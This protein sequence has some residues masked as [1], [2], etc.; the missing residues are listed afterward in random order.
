MPFVKFMQTMRHKLFY[1]ILLWVVMIGC[2]LLNKSSLV[3]WINSCQVRVIVRIYTNCGVDYRM[4]ILLYE[5]C[6]KAYMKHILVSYFKALHIKCHYMH[7]FIFYKFK[8]IKLWIKVVS[9][10]KLS[11]MCNWYTGTAKRIFFFQKEI[12]KNL[13]QTNVVIYQQASISSTI[14]IK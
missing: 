6:K 13:Y 12:A 5:N 11:F 14:M 4:N 7:G 9:I 3:L 1:Y 2:D 8:T 10:E